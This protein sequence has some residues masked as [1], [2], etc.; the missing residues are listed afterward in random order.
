MVKC[1]HSPNRVPGSFQARR[2]FFRTSD[3]DCLV[4]CNGSSYGE[5]RS[6]SSTPA[7]VTRLSTPA[8]AN[9]GVQPMWLSAD[10]I[11]TV[12]TIAP[13][14]PSSPVSWDITG[15]RSA[16]NHSISTRSTL[17]KTSASPTPSTAR[18]ASAAG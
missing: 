8:D 15:C 14:P 10:D 9:V 5:S 13:A 3:S 11:G 12:A 18:A 17:M 6:T 16:G 2:R 1:V 7:P 4:R